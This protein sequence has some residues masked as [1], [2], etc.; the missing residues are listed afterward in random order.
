MTFIIIYDFYIIHFLIHRIFPERVYGT[1]IF[2]ILIIL[3]ENII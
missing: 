3:E 1:L 2:V